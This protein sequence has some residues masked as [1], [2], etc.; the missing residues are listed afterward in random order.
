VN[1]DDPKDFDGTLQEE[2]KYDERTRQIARE[3][4]YLFSKA[5]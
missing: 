4:L 1:Y 3:M 5:V 2:A